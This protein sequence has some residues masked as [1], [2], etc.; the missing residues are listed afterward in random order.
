M[1]LAGPLTRPATNGGCGDT[2]SLVPR[3]PAGPD[4]APPPPSS[5]GRSVPNLTPGA[6]SGTEP[7]ELG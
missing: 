7:G 3:S 4:Q 1:T 5:A 2:R 6:F